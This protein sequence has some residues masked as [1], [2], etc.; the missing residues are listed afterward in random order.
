MQEKNQR[1]DSYNQNGLA[2]CRPSNI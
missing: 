1:F 2:A